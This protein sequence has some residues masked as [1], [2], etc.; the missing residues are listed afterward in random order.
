[1][2]PELNNN[3][4]APKIK[5]IQVENSSSGHDGIMGTRFT[6]MPEITMKLDKI[7]E[8]MVFKTMDTMQKTQ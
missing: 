3:E 2:T 1:M 5:T 8:T 4:I 7:Y 6:L